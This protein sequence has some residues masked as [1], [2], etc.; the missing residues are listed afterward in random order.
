MK[1]VEFRN[2]A[3]FEPCNSRICNSHLSKK[4]TN[5]PAIYYDVFYTLA[6]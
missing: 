1:V 5:Q 4:A 6:R 3:G 2:F